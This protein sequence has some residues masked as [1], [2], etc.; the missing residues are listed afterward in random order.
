M[1]NNVLTVGFFITIL[2]IGG[3]VYINNVY[4]PEQ[5]EIIVES[6]ENRQNAIH[7]LDDWESA[8]DMYYNEGLEAEENKENARKL[9]NGLPFV[10]LIGIVIMFLGYFEPL[11]QK[12][13]KKA[14][15][16]EQKKDN[17]KDQSED[18]IDILNKRYAKGEINKNEYEQMKKD[19]E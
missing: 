16:F 8:W 1:D 13:I 17:G 19:L 15:E 3:M 2:G 10:A 12:E 18:A 11:S 5:E 4:I 9:Y 6:A 7:Y 14:K